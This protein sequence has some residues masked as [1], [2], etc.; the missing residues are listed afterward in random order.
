LSETPIDE[1]FRP[2]DVAAVFGCE[3]HYGPGDF[4]R[5]A[6]LPSG[7]ALEINFKR[8]FPISEEPSNWPR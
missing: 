6:S 2:S 3:K 5:P 7:T 4:L 1:Q 8:C